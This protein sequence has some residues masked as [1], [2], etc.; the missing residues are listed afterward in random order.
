MYKA[1][2]EVAYKFWHRKSLLH[3]EKK[4]AVIAIKNHLLPWALRTPVDTYH[5]A[6]DALMT[7]LM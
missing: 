7:S 6:R 2:G 3:D 4:H 1:C 5:R